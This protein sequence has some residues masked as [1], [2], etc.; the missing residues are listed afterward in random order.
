MWRMKINRKSN[1]ATA[2][3]SAAALDRISRSELIET[4]S[5]IYLCDR[6]GIKTW[7]Q[8]AGAWVQHHRDAGWTLDTF[9]CVG[10][11][12]DYLESVF[13]L[14]PQQSLEAI[15]RLDPH[16]LHNFT[17]WLMSD[18]TGF[19]QIDQLARYVYSLY[20]GRPYAGGIVHKIYYESGEEK[21]MVYY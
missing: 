19:F 6:Q 11:L 21:E 18:G 12:R 4:L 16:Q 7:M 13:G 2:V 17:D 9:R 10:Y 1:L 14:T 5:Y 20:M 3:E 15:E 8:S